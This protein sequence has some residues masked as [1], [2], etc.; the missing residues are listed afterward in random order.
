MLMSDDDSLFGFGNL[1]ADTT[2]NMTSTT[3]YIPNN[4]TPKYG[5]SKRKGSVFRNDRG[6]HF[7]KRPKI[8]NQNQQQMKALYGYITR[9]YHSTIKQ[10]T[11]FNESLDSSVFEIMLDKLKQSTHAIQVYE[12]IS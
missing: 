6:K 9:N 4:T 12:I 10:I 11:Y 1:T 8:S 3:T 2:F 7:L 5:E